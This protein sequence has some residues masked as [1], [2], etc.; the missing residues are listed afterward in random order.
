[1]TLFVLLDFFVLVVSA[2]A[3]G[4]PSIDKVRKDHIG[5][6]WT[7][8]VSDGGSKIIDYVVEK[9]KA[10]EGG[11]KGDWEHVSSTMLK[12]FKE[13]VPTNASK[14]YRAY[15]YFKGLTSTY[16]KFK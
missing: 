2:D 15:M 16:C 9:R 4:R 7:K 13:M 5:V 6:S 10:P 11:H 14:L 8:P 12:T 3:P 1:M